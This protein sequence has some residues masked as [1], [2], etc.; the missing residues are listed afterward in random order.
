M[1]M[2][3][4]HLEQATDAHA[5]QPRFEAAL[6]RVWGYPVALQGFEIP[7]VF[8]RRDS[9]F[10]IQYQMQVFGKERSSP[11]CLCGHLLEPTGP[12]PEYASAHPDRVMV[13]QDPTLIVPVFPFDP[14]LDRLAALDS[15]DWSRTLLESVAPQLG[16][17]NIPRVR[18]TKVLGYRLEKRC[19]LRLTLERANDDSG[20]STV[21]HLLAKIMRPRRLKDLARRLEHLESSGLLHD[22]ADG[23]TLPRTYQ[24]DDRCGVHLMEF[25]DGDSVHELTASPRFESGCRGAAQ[26]L[27][28]LHAAPPADLNGYGV[29]EE[30]AQLRV[31]TALAAGVHPA[32]N[33]PLKDLLS[34]LE[35]HVVARRPTDEITTI[36]RDFYDKQVI[37]SN[38]R[39]TL[40]DIDNMAVGDPAQDY[41]NFMAHLVLRALQQPHN[42]CTIRQGF[43][44]FESG[45][46]GVSS[47]FAQRAAW[48][49]AST[50][51]RLTGLY[52]LR[53]RW[54][55]L[56]IELAEAAA[57]R[58]ITGN[59]ATRT[60]AT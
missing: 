17:D 53:P 15:D 13:F 18:E 40:L 38:D 8:P 10:T 14:K 47:G 1:K 54:R 7:R 45:Y 11:L 55:H 5:M 49:Q 20:D 29:A 60:T 32:L 9:G 36:H 42:G 33:E 59:D 37:Y 21:C 51:L 43:A 52:S 39:T 2:T 57:R 35:D 22:S 31:W 44:G 25:V 27:R 28:K 41:G 48:W 24:I 4:K 30:I 34:A 19:V 23:V 3:L 12:P 50:L 16:F 6:E 58:L 26:A 56:A 46:G